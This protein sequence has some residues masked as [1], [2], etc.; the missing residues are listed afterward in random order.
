MSKGSRYPRRVESAIPLAPHH[1]PAEVKVGRGSKAGHR[2][3]RDW[4]AP[5]GGRFEPFTGHSAYAVLA[6]SPDSKSE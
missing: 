1:A 6:H 4:G 3:L 2:V 5:S